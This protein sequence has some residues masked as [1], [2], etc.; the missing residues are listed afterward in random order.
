MVKAGSYLVL[1]LAPAIAGT[2][3]SDVIAVAGAFTFALA[4][5]LA[6]GQSNGKKVLAYST[7]SNLG[8]I[9][10]CAGLNTPLA[11]GAALMILCFHAASKALLFM[12]L[13]TIEQAIGSRDIEDMGGI[14]YRM[15]VTTVMALL[16]MVS[17][18]L[19]PF[20][21]LIS[22]WMAIEASVTSP[23]VLVLVVIGSALTV[24]FWA[25]WIG[26]IQTVSFHERFQF[27]KLPLSVLAT[28]AALVVVVV[29]AGIGSLLFYQFVMEP[30]VYHQMAAQGA[31]WDLMRK[32]GDFMIWPLLG[33]LGLALLAF[34][35]AARRVTP[36]KVSRPFLCGENI[37]GTTRT[38]EFR[39]VGDQTETAWTTSWYLKSWFSE[40]TV[41]L[42]ANLAAALLVLT[43]FAVAGAH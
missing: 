37:E 33:V 2:R 20:G 1:R 13:G 36:A 23:L 18:L 34:L 22:K 21:M 38:Y 9:V 40:R 14:M 35:V 6:V 24:F 32:A 7:I 26:R 11:Y 19:P 12:C 3:L 10:A 16:G 25:K 27:E 29:G 28:M 8:L 39:G 41:T 15:P 43:V 5:L 42:W 17:M 30:I 4:S 31:S